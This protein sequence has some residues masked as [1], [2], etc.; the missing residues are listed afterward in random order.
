MTE[1]LTK[2][3]VHSHDLPAQEMQMVLKF[4]KISSPQGLRGAALEDRLLTS[5]TLFLHQ[6]AVS[7]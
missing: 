1:R 6:E 5:L 3:T 4:L 7:H 2:S